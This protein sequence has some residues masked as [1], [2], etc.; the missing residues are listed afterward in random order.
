[1]KGFVLPYLFMPSVLFWIADAHALA[2]N[3]T[4]GGAVYTDLDSP[5]DSGLKGVE[6]CVECG[7]GKFSACDVTSGPWGGWQVSDVPDGT[8]TVTPMLP[9]WCFSHVEGGEIGIP[10]PIVIVVDGVHEGQNL[11][12]QFLGTTGTSYCCVASEDCDDGEACTVD[13]CSAGVCASTRNDCPADFDCDGSVGPAD[14]ALLLGSWGPCPE[15]VADLDGD[16]EVEAFDL[17][18]LLGSWGACL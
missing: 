2:D 4:V 6:V 17:A 9:G 16:G 7:G 18:I 5:I 12:L 14:L 3:F 1:M 8:C 13:E 11:S 15:C 10:A